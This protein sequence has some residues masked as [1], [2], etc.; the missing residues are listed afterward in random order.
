MKILRRVALCVAIAGLGATVL[1]CSF[2]ARNGAPK[3]EKPKEKTKAPAA[4]AKEKTNK[5]AAVA[6]D[7]EYRRQYDAE[8]AEKNEDNRKKYDSE[9]AELKAGHEIAMEDYRKAQQK[10]V[11][12]KQEFAA[13]KLER[14]ASKLLVIARGQYDESK[15]LT[16]KGSVEE[17]ARYMKLAQRRLNEIIAKFPDTECA[18]DS[19]VLLAGKY[20]VPRTIPAQPSPPIAPIEPR[21]ILPPEPERI[22]S[23]HEVRE[24]EAKRRAEQEAAE[25]KRRTEEEYEADGLVL[26]R[27]SLGATTDG[28]GGNVTGTVINR[29][30]NTLRYAEIRFN[31]Y[32]ESGAQIGSALA[33]INDLEPGARWNFKASSLGR[34]FSSYKVSR[35]SGF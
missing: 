2:G 13:A 14:E 27:K 19:K 31:L 28:F 11:K 8:V 12:A 3:D 23:L 34:Q 9:V 16:R 6:K 21:L 26:L 17:A 10:H 30:S 35:L 32:D 33:N 1:A 7:E 22:P 15:E 5:L 24:A 29:R 20:V 18:K 4:V 25:V